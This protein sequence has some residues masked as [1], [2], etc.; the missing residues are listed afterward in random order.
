MVAPR[1]ETIGVEID[2][3]DDTCPEG[4]AADTGTG[5]TRAPSTSQR[6]PTRTG[7]K[8]PGNAYEARI[9]N[10]RDPRVSQISWPVPTSVAIAAK[11]IGKF[12][13]GCADRLGQ[14]LGQPAAADQARTANSTSR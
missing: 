14:P 3:D 1:R 8:I 11:R 9:A 10:A 7:G 12:H 4:A 2:G 5:L 6:P 13:D